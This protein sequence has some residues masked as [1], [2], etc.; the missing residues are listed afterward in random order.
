MQASTLACRLDA[1]VVVTVRARMIVR[2]SCNCKVSRPDYRYI[3]GAQ[4]K[5]CVGR[6]VRLPVFG[7]RSPARVVVGAVRHVL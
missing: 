1:E 3:S 6:R 7:H 5:R 2:L 4:G